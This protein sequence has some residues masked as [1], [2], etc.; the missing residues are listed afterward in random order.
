MRITRPT[1]WWIFTTEYGFSRIGGATKEFAQHFQQARARREQIE[2][3]QVML[4]QAKDLYTIKSQVEEAIEYQQDWEYEHT[5]NMRHD[6][7]RD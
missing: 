1:D 6:A 4:L 7:E 2:P 3:E 5:E